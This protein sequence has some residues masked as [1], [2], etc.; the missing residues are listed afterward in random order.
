MHLNNF[1]FLSI[2]EFYFQLLKHF[3]EHSGQYSA[4]PYSSPRHLRLVPAICTTLMASSTTIRGSLTA[5]PS[6]ACCCTPPVLADLFA[7]HSSSILHCP[8]R[9]IHPMDSCTVRAAESHC[10]AV[11]C[12]L[13]LTLLHALF[14]SVFSVLLSLLCFTGTFFCKAVLLVL[15]VR[16]AVLVMFFCCGMLLC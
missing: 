4:R 2:F 16:A 14:F 8:I 12:H 9:T 7:A 10:P 15:Y 6:P 13:W 3:K 5:S 11:V 1:V